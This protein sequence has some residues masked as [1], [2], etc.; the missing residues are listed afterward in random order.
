MKEINHVIIKFLMMCWVV[1]IFATV[2]DA[3]EISQE[4]KRHMAR[5]TA[6]MKYAKSTADYQDA[7][8][9]FKKA[10][11]YAPDWS[12]AWFNLGVA[13]ESSGDFA[14]AIK[15]FRTYLEKNPKAADR[16]KVE[17]RIYELEY[18]QEKARKKITRDKEE[19]QRKIAGLSGVWRKQDTGS[20]WPV[21]VSGTRLIIKTSPGG[22]VSSTDY[23]R[24]QIVAPHATG[25]SL[26]GVVREWVIM[27][28]ND[29]GEFQAEGEI[30]NNWRKIV[31]RFMS[32]NVHLGPSP[33]VPSS[34]CRW[35]GT[36]F[37]STF[38]LVRD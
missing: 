13:Q 21:N 20:S 35:N 2:L 27:C 7:I 25:A 33:N 16:D 19:I 9:E 32:D 31:I 38:I 4:A 36:P 8:T 1:F 26:T 6:A 30:T 34:Q 3:A 29:L 10:I 18:R 15:S 11:E 17:T 23:F 12:D 22:V 24:G 37:Y 28:L 5:G 14:G